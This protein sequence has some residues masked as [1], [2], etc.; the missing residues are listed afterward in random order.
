MG[1]FIGA[2]LPVDVVTVEA[3]SIVA[4][5]S[6]CHAITIITKDKVTVGI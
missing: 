6:R 2:L 4:L 1:K 5:T 3:S